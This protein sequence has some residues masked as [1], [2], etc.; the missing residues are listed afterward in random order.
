MTHRTDRGVFNLRFLQG[1][2]ATNEGFYG[3]DPGT[4]GE[5]EFTYGIESGESTVLGLRYVVLPV[6]AQRPGTP[7][8]SYR[9]GDT[10]KPFLAAIIAEETPSERL[11]LSSITDAWLVLTEL[12]PTS[13]S[14]RGYLLEW[15]AESNLLR[16]DW[17]QDDLLR[18]GR[19]MV[20]IRLQ[21]ESGR[22]MSIEAND[23]TLLEIMDSR[24]AGGMPA[25]TLTT[26][27]P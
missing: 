3:S 19:F 8:W 22:Y 13:S 16:R 15:D 4:Y 24:V 20:T 11:D 26:E 7:E 27:P 12:S 2:Y 23:D 14:R 6:P 25:A 1:G 9:I 18:R 10:A 17:L 5:P 21:F